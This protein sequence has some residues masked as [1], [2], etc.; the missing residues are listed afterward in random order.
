MSHSL[1]ENN[2]YAIKSGYTHRP[3]PDYYADNPERHAEGVIW[4][5]EVY[6]IAAGI[7]AACGCDTILDIGCGTAS[8]LVALHPR[9]RIIGVDFGRNLEFCRENYPQGEWLEADLEQIDSLPIDATKLERAVIVCS[10]VIEHLIDPMPLL[11]AIRRLLRNCSYALISTPDRNLLRGMQ[12]QG[13][14]SNLHHVREWAM[15]ELE[16]LVRS[17]GIEQKYC[18]LTLSN[19]LSEARNTILIV[20]KGTGES[21][22]RDLLPPRVPGWWYRGRVVRRSFDVWRNSIK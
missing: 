9:F 6:E 22:E 21:F 14:P 8:K 4:Q 10:D 5:P 17:F 16:T 3:A 12:D 13:P 11:R 18:G 15:P 1:S 20:A 2:Q 19:N 7:A